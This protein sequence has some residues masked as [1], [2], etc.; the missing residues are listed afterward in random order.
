MR[1][2]RSHLL[3]ATMVVLTFGMA[4]C[5]GS[6]GGGVDAGIKTGTNTIGTGGGQTSD[7]FIDKVMQII[8][9]TTEHDE[10]GSIDSVTVT[11]PEDAEPVPVS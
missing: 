11:R 2:K 10:P 8:G 3:A 9:V 5:G 6:S 4:S 7:A 1:I